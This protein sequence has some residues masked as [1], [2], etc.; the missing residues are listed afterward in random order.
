MEILITLLIICAVCA[1]LIWLINQI[2]FGPAILKN[3]LIAIV[4]IA[5]LIKVW[6]LLG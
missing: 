6:P 2:N 1:V 4:V 3:I 5:A